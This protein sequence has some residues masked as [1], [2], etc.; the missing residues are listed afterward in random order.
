[1]SNGKVV[2]MHDMVFDRL[3]KLGTKVNQLVLDGKR[4]PHELCEL[5]QRVLDRKFPVWHTVDLGVYTNLA[6]YQEAFKDA[7]LSIQDF[8]ERRFDAESR[9]GELE[10][11]VEQ[12]TIPLVRLSVY[13]LGFGA[14]SIPSYRQV[15]EQGYHLGL[16]PC[17]TE[18]AFALRL[19]HDDF[20]GMIATKTFREKS[21]SDRYI[22]VATGRGVELK[23]IG[24]GG[25]PDD[26]FEP[27]D[28]FIFTLP[29]GRHVA[30]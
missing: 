5:Y 24:D 10:F 2:V 29:W 15:C 30:G 11:S 26:F 17:S 9:R 21:H 6:E 12:S 13:D 23:T 18:V 1:M 16:Q 20:G 3:Y 7:G 25:F 14:S 19:Q 8:D 27:G 22:Y 4:S 28:S